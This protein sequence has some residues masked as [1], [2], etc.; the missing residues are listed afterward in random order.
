VNEREQV[1]LGEDRIEAA[2]VEVVHLVGVRAVVEPFADLL[3]DGVGEGV[4]APALPPMKVAVADS[5][6]RTELAQV[7]P[8]LTRFG[9]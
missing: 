7:S 6:A 8:E 2:R 9:G 1:A 3:Q 4:R 5:L